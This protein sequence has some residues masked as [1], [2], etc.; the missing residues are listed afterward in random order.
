MGKIRRI[1]KV[2][3]VVVIAALLLFADTGYLMVRPGSAEDLSRF[4]AV[5]K[6]ETDDAGAFYLVTVSQQNATPIFFL[7]ALSNPYVDLQPRRRVIPSDMDPKDYTE[8]MRRWM[9]ESQNLARVIALRRLGNE[10]PIES[11]G[12]QVVEVGK[13]SPAKGILQAGDVIRGVD[14]RPVFLADELVTQVQLRPVGEPVTLDI[15]RDDEP[16]TVTIE[17]AGH[18]D[19]PDRAALRVYVRTLNWQP[20]LP[21]EIAI[22]VGQIT[23]PS[24]GLMFVL[25]ILN[26]LEPKDLTAGQKIA[27]TGTINLRE[28]V[29]PIGGVRQ[30]VRAAENIGAAYFIVPLEN[31]EEAKTAAGN[32][33]LVPVG[34]LAEALSF[35]DGIAGDKR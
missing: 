35:L 26:Q 5:E 11:D 6:T 4:I 24:A 22:E 9:E 30:K 21:V 32:I 16:M 27:G 2:A 29:G 14:G 23:G 15:R 3:A 12:V 28:E 31:Y 25:E 33:K 17:T 34:T 8:L 19:Q 18:T 13:D 10:V 7:Y 20:Q 1:L